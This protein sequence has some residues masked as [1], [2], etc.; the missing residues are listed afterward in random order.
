MDQEI[1]SALVNSAHESILTTDQT[2]RILFC[3]KSSENLFNTSSASL[4]NENIFA[5]LISEDVKEIKRIIGLLGEESN[6]GLSYLARFKRPENAMPVKV[7]VKKLIVKNSIQILFV[8]TPHTKEEEEAHKLY[9]LLA[10]NAYDINIMFEG[11][12][13]IYV[14]PSVKDFL[15]YDVEEIDSITFWN[16]LI[17]DEDLEQYLAQLRDDQKNKVPFSYYTYR[18]RH[19]DGRYRWFETKIRR[20]FRNDQQVVEMATSVDITQRK[21]FELE[22]AMQKEFIEQLFDTD[23]NLIFVRDGNG[24]MIYCNKAVAELVGMA[25]ED[26]LAQEKNMFP[27]SNGQIAKYLQMEE[28]VINQG[29]EI[30]IEEQISDKN[31]VVNYFQTIKKPLKTQDGDVNMLNIS[32]NINKI[33]YYEKETQNVMK[34][35]NEFF[36][37]MSH[38]IRTPMNAILGMTELLL[39]RNPRKDQSKLLNTLH[40]SSKNLLSLIND[41]LDFSKIE[42]GKIEIEE[43][44]FNLKE[45]IENVMVS[46]RP[47]AMDKNLNM[48]FNVSVEVPAVINGDYIKLSQILNNLLSNA[49]KFTARGSISLEADVFKQTKS[50]HLLVFKVS[51][52]GI[53]IAKDKLRDIFNPFHQANKSTARVYGGT[54]LG[55]SIVQNLVL[56]QK[57]KISVESEENSGSVF[58]VY[59]PFKHADTSLPVNSL[60]TSQISSFNWKMKLH[61]LYVEDVTTN[62][63][64]IEEILGDWGIS[65]DMAS[66]GFEALKMIEQKNYDLI[67]MDIQM[68]GIDG[69]ETTRRIRAKEE[70]YFKS[71]PIVALTASTTDATRDEIFLCGMQDFV[72]KPINVDDLRA[73]I[74]EH[75]SVVDGFKDMKIID[76]EPEE[77]DKSSKIIF[78]RTDK[79]FLGNLV[80]YQEF[81]RMTIEEFRTNLDL[82]SVSIFNEDLMA[83]R[84]LRHRMKSLIATFGMEELLK[85]LDEVKTKLKAGE[86]TLKEKKEFN[87]ALEYH[88]QFLIDSLTNKLASL[89]WQ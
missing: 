51:D 89:K 69:L 38:E 70:P 36:S 26:F 80:R 57:G 58:T 67:L 16:S 88:V 64:L 9:K 18:Q 24:R 25:R 83:Y 75:S 54:G 35:R 44:N 33:K 22:L 40:F 17:Y 49:I 55:L 85:L 43:V 21:K 72:L 7:E 2:G 87:K 15:G 81:L 77:I 76:T 41:I 12:E 29:E 30:L 3:N 19:K 10:E 14:S 59:L 71:I 6:G 13:L 73:K 84:Q 62:Q 56:L 66:D 20:E 47:K 23:P 52:T 86:I 82:L 79:L 74:V 45:L 1:L 68:P 63:Y 42:S 46:Q 48:N 32:T 50:G 37:A 27:A 11:G 65:V 78:D 60:P 5:L 34:A 31:G 8:I 39:R 53:G 28:K 61:V 4:L